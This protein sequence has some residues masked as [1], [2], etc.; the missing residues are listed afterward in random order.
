[1]IVILPEGKKPYSQFYADEIKDIRHVN[2]DATILINSYLGIVPIELDEMYPFSQSIMPQF[3][4]LETKS[5]LAEI[6]SQFLNGRAVIFWNGRK[7]LD[8]MSPSLSNKKEN[9]D[10]RRISTLVD[11]QFGKKVSESLLRGTIKIVKSKKTGK[12]RNVYC[13]RKH[14]LSIRAS[15]GMFTLK[16]AGGQL[17]QKI[18]PFPHLR[19]IIDDEAVPFIKKGK[20]V[21]AKFVIDC[22]RELRPFEECLVVNSSDEFLAIGTSILNPMEML[23]FRYGVAVKIREHIGD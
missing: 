3:P 9:S 19:V 7:T 11:F 6:L 15:D 23:S 22:D 20:S 5:Y 14:I 4:D 13:N 2:K 12:I 8:Q 1:M 16:I 17:L 10:L 18:L 21:F